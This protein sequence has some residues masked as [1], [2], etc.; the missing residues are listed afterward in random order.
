MQTR[1]RS[2]ATITIIGSV[3]LMLILVVGTVWMG[4]SA[5][6]GTDNAARTVS[7]LYLDELAGRREQVVEHNLQEKIKVIHTAVN[8]MTEEDLSD[9]QHFQAYQSRIKKLFTLDKFAFVDTDG[10]IYTSTGPQTNID[11][12]DFDYRTILTTGRF[13]NRRSQSSI[14]R[15]TRV[16][17]SLPSLSRFLSRANPFPFVLW[18]S[19][20][21][22]CWPACPWTTRARI[23]PSATSIPAKAFR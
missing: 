12:Y 21:R 1:Q 13:Q 19:T 18:R 8:L 23:P 14:R 11:E 6:K 3:I 10:L 7:R 17:S 16:R 20:C 9:L 5:R 22:R 2:T 4:Q 15:A